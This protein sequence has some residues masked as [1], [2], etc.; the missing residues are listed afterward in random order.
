MY[1]RSMAARSRIA[2][3]TAV[4]AIVVLVLALPLSSAA[5]DAGEPIPTDDA[6]SCIP[7]DKCCKV[8][9]A[10]KACGNSCIQATKTCHKGRG[11]ACNATEVCGSAP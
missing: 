6:P 2:S 11:C 4:L 7:A 10:G 5:S 9:S 1:D 8:C 3:R